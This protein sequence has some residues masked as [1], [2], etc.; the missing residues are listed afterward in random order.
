MKSKKLVFVSVILLSSFACNLLSPSPSGELPADL[1]ATQNSI[2][3]TQIALDN[4]QDNDPTVESAPAATAEPAPAEDND[5]A[6]GSSEE[7][8]DEPVSEPG[9]LLLASTFGSVEPW[10]EGGAC[11]KACHFAD[12][13]GDGIADF[14]AED[15]DGIYVMRSTGNGFAPFEKWS[16]G[17]CHKACHFV[18]VTGDGIA[19]FIAEDNDGIYVMPSTGV[20]FQVHTKWSG[21]ACHKACHFADVTGDGIADFIAEDNNGIFVMASTGSGFQPHQEWSGGACHV[22]CHFA[23]VTG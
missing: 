11:H 13:T 14:I 20:G 1:A 6:G 17:S 3:L 12:V 8:N 9:Q 16:G 18:D 23:D 2:Q 22:A 10:G 21:G 15:N 7:A 19:D 5:T 4:L